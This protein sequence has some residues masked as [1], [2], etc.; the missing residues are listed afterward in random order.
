MTSLLWRCRASRSQGSRWA[1]PQSADG[2]SARINNQAVKGT[3]ITPIANARM[4]GQAGALR[5]KR[6]RQGETMMNPLVFSMGFNGYQWI[7]RDLIASQ[8]RYCDRHG[9]DYVMVQKPGFT[10]LLKECAWLKL[11]LAADALRAGRPWV[12]F[13]DADVRISDSAPAIESTFV[14]G[15]TFYLAKGRSG[16]INSGVIVATNTIDS[17]KMLDDIVAAA[18]RPIPAED[19]VGWGEN[20]HVIHYLKDSQLFHELNTRWNN[21]TNPG[22]SD[23]F[24]HYTGPMKDEFTLDAVGKLS[25]RIAKYYLKA[26]KAAGFRDD[27]RLFQSRL[28]DLQSAV[29][30]HYPVFKTG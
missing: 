19:D 20:G 22:S 7:Y 4:S 25:K 26:M 23:Y 5:Q 30:R 21:T 28:A 15:N 3:I 6:E 27:H 17:I 9:Y 2:L 24:R 18:Q 1:L 14:S 8:R 13:L 16:R 12:L 10:P 11:P 29:A